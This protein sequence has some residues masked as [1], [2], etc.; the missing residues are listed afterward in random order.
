MHL[1]E[2][3]IHMRTQIHCT[4]IIIC[5]SG[6]LSRLFIYLLAYLFICEFIIRWTDSLFICEH[7]FRGER[8]RTFIFWWEQSLIQNRPV[9]RSLPLSECLFLSVHQTGSLALC[10]CPSARFSAAICPICVCLS[11]SVFS[12]P[13]QCLSLSLSLSDY[14][15]SEWMNYEN[16][17]SENYVP[18]PDPHKSFFEFQKDLTFTSEQKKQLGKWQKFVLFTFSVTTLHNNQHLGQ[19]QHGYSD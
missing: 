4:S 2:K 10:L 1:E 11:F 12:S 8:G 13:S 19:T 15:H 6:V 14:V 7:G 3:I 16:A 17:V 18:T 5:L 9:P